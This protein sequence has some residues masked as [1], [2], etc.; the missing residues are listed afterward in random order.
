MHGFACAI[1]KR[2]GG[3]AFPICRKPIFNNC[4]RKN[5]ELVTIL[6]YSKSASC[7]QQNLQANHIFL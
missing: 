5:G 6:I 1:A 4:E 2:A 3:I 7:I